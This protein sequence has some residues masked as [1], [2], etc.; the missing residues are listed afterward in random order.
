MFGPF[1][2]GAEPIALKCP[3]CQPQPHE[4][5][6]VSRPPCGNHFRFAPS[7]RSFPSSFVVPESGHSPQRQLVAF[8]P[9]G[10]MSCFEVDGCIGADERPGRWRSNAMAQLRA[11]VSVIATGCTNSLQK[12]LHLDMRRVQWI[13]SQVSSIPKPMVRR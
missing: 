12:S 13:T 1:M 4:Q 7:Y 3:Q 2:K 9:K 5:T 8:A 11:F 10:D 6:V